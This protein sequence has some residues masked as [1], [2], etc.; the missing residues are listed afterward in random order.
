MSTINYVCE[1]YIPD[2]HDYVTVASIIVACHGE[3]DYD[4][5]LEGLWCILF[6][7]VIEQVIMEKYRLSVR[8]DNYHNLW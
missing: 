2:V 5:T 6:S 4:C 7:L 8:I 3:S 1:F